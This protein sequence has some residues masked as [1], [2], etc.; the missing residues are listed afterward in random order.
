MRYLRVPIFLAC[1]LFCS[2]IDVDP[3]PRIIQDHHRFSASLNGFPNSIQGITQPGVLNPFGSSQSLNG[4]LRFYSLCGL[5]ICVLGYALYFFHRRQLKFR[6][7]E[8]LDVVSDRTAE[9][10]QEINI[11][12]KTEEE[13][14]NS[15]TLLMSTFDQLKAAKESAESA[16]LSKNQF[17]ANISHELRTP[18]NG[19]IGM[20]QLT[21]ETDLNSEQ[22]EYL[23]MV[24]E[25]ADSLLGLLNDILD[26]TKIEAGKLRLSMLRF[27]LHSSVEKI[28]KT[29]KTPA[30]QKNLELTCEFGPDVPE[31]VVGDE[32]RIRQIL[33]NLIG[34][35]IKFTSRGSVYVKVELQEK[36]TE[37]CK[38]HFLVKDTGIGIPVSKHDIIFEAFTQADS[39]TT[40]KYGGTGLGLSISLEL[41]SAM[42]GSMWLESKEGG[43]S[44][45]HFSIPLLNSKSILDPSSLDDTK[46]AT[47]IHDGHHI[48][49]VDDNLINQRLISEILGKRG[50]KVKVASD[51]REALKMYLENSFDVILMDIQMPIM[52]GLEAASRIRAEEKR[53]GHHVAIIGITAHVTQ[54]C[55]EK[56]LQA[57]MDDFMTKPFQ[58]E[59]FL[60]ILGTIQTRQP[61]TVS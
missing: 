18:M 59:K 48:L 14:K 30:N 10:Q 11:R 51:G 29:F 15:M 23:G 9:L 45:F 46:P 6:E 40:R 54:N 4:N 3:K 24:K 58:V 2:F 39:S 32:S 33:V 60:Q 19:I 56:C 57:G 52:D 49:V 25:S 37:L 21:L 53:T 27:Q 34:N 38:V 47:M 8:L 41:V 7:Q 42:N 35:A 16:N 28:V 20:T 22:R 50:N 44:T 13:L 61:S 12:K 43:G 31:F 36:N 55:L 26:F 1:I 17:L 5:L